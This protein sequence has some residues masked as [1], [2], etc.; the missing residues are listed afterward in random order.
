[1]KKLIFF[2]CIVCRISAADGQDSVRL[3]TL[4][5]H[6]GFYLSHRQL[7]KDKPV[8]FASML[9]PENVTPRSYF[10]NVLNSETISY[11]DSYGILQT[12]SL[13]NIWG[14][15]SDGAVFVNMGGAFSQIQIFGTLCYFAANVTVRYEVPSTSFAYAGFGPQARVQSTV[16]MRQYILELETGQYSEVSH[17]A[18]LGFLQ[19]DANLYNQYNALSS[20]NKSKQLLV[21]LRKYN[22][23]HPLLIPNKP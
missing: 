16:E 5:L 19:K 12:I 6:E 3:S 10:C 11:F 4:Q 15:C 18:M 14:F 20:S 21:F 13:E 22:Q 23:T 1:M 7:Y 8:P 2:L 17:S 9:L